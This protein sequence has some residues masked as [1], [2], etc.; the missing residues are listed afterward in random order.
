MFPGGVNPKQMNQMMKQFGIKNQE[1][2]AKEVV[3]TLNNGNKIIFDAPQI[4]CI[5]M[6][7]EKTYTIAG[8]TREVGGLPEEDIEMVAEQANVSKEEA[9]K[10]LAESNGDI[11]E[12][13]LKLKK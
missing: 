11:A 4:Q 12:A 3:I 2:D 8:A 13:I 5:E 10:A 7:G 6:R 1:V 9:K